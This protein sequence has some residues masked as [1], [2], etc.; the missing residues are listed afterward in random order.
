MA[1]NVENLFDL[2]DNGGEY[3]EYRP[4]HCGWNRETCLRKYENIS[5][6]IAAVHPDIVILCEIENQNALAMLHDAL[7]QRKCSYKYDVIADRPNPSSTCPAILSRYPITGT[8]FH[9]IPEEKAGKTRNILEADIAIGT[10]T[11]KVFANHWPSKEHPESYRI[12]AA[13]ILKERLMSMR[14]GADYIIAGDFNTNYDEW[15]KSAAKNS[16]GGEEMTALGDVLRTEMLLMDGTRRYTTQQDVREFKDSLF[17]YDL[18][19]ELAPDYRYSYQHKN[20]PETIDHI[21]LPASLFD[22]AGM[23]YIDGSFSVFRWNGRLLYDGKPYRWRIERS[24]KGMRHAGAGYSDHLPLIVKV[25][26]CS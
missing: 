25:R 22:S 12:T 2:V 13:N 26:C 4:G 16:R 7:K 5:G 20:K 17:H 21:L 15:E 8:L 11:L 10:C 19:L 6:A 24:R 9:G 3:P 14:P 23:S 18:W 1:Y